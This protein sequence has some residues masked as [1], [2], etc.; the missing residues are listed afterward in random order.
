MKDFINL[1]I[2][3]HFFLH[4]INIK[5]TPKIHYCNEINHSE[6]TGLLFQTS[7]QNTSKYTYLPSFIFTFRF[8]F[9]ILF[10]FIHQKLYMQT[11]SPKRISNYLHFILYIYPII[12]A[13]FLLS[14][15]S[16]TQDQINGL[17]RFMSR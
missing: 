14:E 7:N 2:F 5:N 11:V 16:Y 1:N 9:L 13:S 17:K 8:I 10:Y 12:H 6:W 15:V 3:N 4:H